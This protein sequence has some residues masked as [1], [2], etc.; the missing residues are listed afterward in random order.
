MTAGRAQEAPRAL[1]M[2]VYEAMPICPEPLASLGGEDYS[3]CG[4]DEESAVHQPIH[5]FLVYHPPAAKATSAT[6]ANMAATA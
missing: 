4:E 1:L 3:V 6:S 5:R 2:R